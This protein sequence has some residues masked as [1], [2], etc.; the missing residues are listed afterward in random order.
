[1]R[2][3]RRALGIT[4]A[5]GVLMFAAEAGAQTTPSVVDP[6]LEVVPVTTGLAQPVQMEFIND[7]D[8]FVLE[9]P[10]GQVKLVKDGGA[11][12]VV[13]DL[14][15]NS[16]SERGLLG[17]ALDKYFRHN[18]YVY[19]YWSETTQPAD[20]A[21]RRRRAAD[22]QPARPVQVGRHDADLRQ[23]AAP[24]P[25]VPGRRDEPDEPGRPG[26]PRQPQRR[27]RPGRPG[28]QDL[29][30]GRR[31]GSPR[32]DAEPV[33]RPVR[34]G[35]PGRP[36][37]R[38]GHHQ[39]PPDGR[40]P[41]PEHGRHARRRTTRSTSWAPSAAARSGRTSRRSTPTACATASA[42]RSTRSAATSGSRRTATTP[43]RRSTAR[44]RASTPAGRR[45]WARSTAW[46]SSARSRRPARRS[47][48]IPRRRPATTASSRSAGCRRTS[49]TN[50]RDA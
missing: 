12:T 20:N 3:T 34:R 44:S 50:P 19:L 36:V 21:R 32:A 27:R 33:R 46:R 1:M 43:S 31:H 49:P 7:T 29:P 35:H 16:N 28:R 25:R 14:T 15:V 37:R 9:K 5:A 40:H 42:W 48:R 8:F 22:G 10:T 6:K 24:Q 47:R 45:S 2:A 4:A 26:L 41:A 39:R 11:P 18:G 30:A 13:L 38:P 23:D 17:I